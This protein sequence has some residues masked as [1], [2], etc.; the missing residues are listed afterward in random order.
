[1]VARNELA[2]QSQKLPML[3]IVANV[4]PD[5]ARVVSMSSFEMIRRTTEPTD[6]TDKKAS[7]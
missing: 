5:V 3:A 2:N 4:T 7:Q 6:K 1:M